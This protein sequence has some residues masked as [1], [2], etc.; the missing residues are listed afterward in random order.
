MAQK[1]I[2][3]RT[4]REREAAQVPPRLGVRIVAVFALVQLLLLVAL[5]LLFPAK[6]GA[7]PVK[8]ELSVNATGG[9]ARLVFTLAQE[10]EAEVRLANGIVIIAFKQPVDVPVDRVVMNAASY[11]NAAR[12]DP[13]G[14]AVRLALNR[15]VTVNSMAAGEKLF[16]D[17]LPEGWTGLPPGLPQEVVE[18]LAKRARE[19]EKK[20]RQRQQMARQRTLPPVR[21][22]VGAQ[23]TFTRYTFGLPALI[24]V[25]TE[26]SE[27]KITMTFEAPL[28]FDL[29][30][31]QAALPPMVAAVETQPGPD[32]TSVQF[33][34]IGKVDVRTFR[35]DNNYIVDVQPIK[36]REGGAETAADVAKAAAR[37][38]KP[39]APASPPP[40]PAAEKPAAPA[41]PTKP[42][43]TK[44]A[45]AKPAEAKPAE[46]A[47]AE[48]TDKSAAP[49]VDTIASGQ[50]AHPEPPPPDTTPAA[51]AIAAREPADSKPARADP[52]APVVVDVR[53]Q[54]EAM[55]LTFPFIEPT[56]AAMFRRADTI[57]LVFDSRAPID[58][59]KLVAQ[60]G[61]SIRSASVT[62]SQDGQVVQL[63][64][65]RPKLTS[66]GADGATWTVI[67][68]D[69]MLEPTQPLGLTRLPQG[70]GRASVMIPFQAP[71]K[72]HRLSDAEIGDTLF[73]VTALG[74][75]RG[76]LKPQEFVE[77]NALVSTHGVVIQPL[78]DDVA[79]EIGADKIVVGR[80]GGLTL[81]N[82]GARPAQ[83]AQPSAD[84]P[85]RAAAAL[86][87]LDPQVWGFDREADFL[88]RQTHLVAAAAS[89]EETRRGP[90]QLELARFYLAREL[91]AE[92][93]GVLDVAA[94]D[95]RAGPDSNT[96]LLRAIAN[97]R[98]GRGADALKD[99]SHA[100]VSKRNDIALWRALAQAQQGKWT[101]ARDGLRSLDMATAT[102]PLELQRYAFQEAVRTAVEVRDFGT[103][104]SLLSEFETLG[105]TRERDAD[106][107]VLK[108]RVMEG[109]GRL[110]EALTLYRSA[111]ESPDLE[112]AAR[113]RLREVALRQSIGDLKRDEATVA[114]ETLTTAWRGDETEAEALQL[115]GRYY[116]EDGRYRDAFQVMRTALTAYPHSEMTRRI[117]DEAAVAF[118]SL[119][120]GG[121]GDNMPTIEALSLFYDFRDLTP[122]GRRGDEMIR[123]LADRLVSVDLLDQAAEVLQHQVDNRLQG[124]ARAQVAVKLAV[125]Y[126]MSRKPDR[127]IQ[128]LRT[129]RSADL[130]NELRNQRLLLE[131]RAQS[132][133]GRPELALE[134]VANLAGREVE[135][136]RADVLWK[137]RRWG[138]AGEQIEKFYGERWRDFAP[139]GETE[140]ADVLRAAIAY[141]LADDAIGLDRFR[142]K[143][144]P[145]MAEGVDRRAFEVVTAPFNTNAPEFA[146][147][148]RRIAATDTLD[149]FLRDI[150]ARF[151]ETAAPPAAPAKPV[152]PGTDASAAARR[153]G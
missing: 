106:L 79:A 60:S 102:L 72:L 120:L 141:A 107:N 135:R 70:H 136:L 138:E 28:R 37:P 54:G 149:A 7:E 115:L 137:A 59:A 74:P 117:H 56:S 50:P 129:T 2:T 51:P 36:S 81:S 91:T 118:D 104:T 113:G 139:L 88:D 23:P 133:V 140:R 6:A 17:L 61:R 31:V 148:A 90:A 52:T 66:A 76:F 131:A 24:A 15:K 21:V 38:E 100:A 98:L 85:R 146:E 12:R 57:W 18:E 1:A 58:I 111:A 4:L 73:V 11:V 84:G 80:P 127:A 20:A 46:A 75:A 14:T 114:L 134:V 121:K 44:P 124:A 130:P 143:Y 47:S 87:T 30:D 152:K 122:V 125:I 69:M 13:D 145:K 86:F 71:R 5:L 26:R 96:L 35:E 126:L 89:A 67:V 19:A 94:S 108:G 142:T 93:K 82:A 45:E 48:T 116:A 78:A 49:P 9:Y 95:E 40:T 32:A 112:A 128:T 153:A 33:E 123:K 110:A 150:R 53:H 92:A 147:I 41:V 55:R 39:Q 119:F 10:T 83:A 3:L 64:L 16:V 132:E 105:T 29:A 25:S 63:K 97:I 99:L 42:A 62:R 65:D 151:P 43:E 22:R 144:A 68:G 77:F 34:F 8:G 27:D 101:E 109:L 103:A